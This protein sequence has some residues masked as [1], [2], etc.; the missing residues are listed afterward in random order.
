MM[1]EGVEITE[2]REPL[3]TH[4]ML[5]EGFLANLQRAGSTLPEAGTESLS[6]TAESVLQQDPNKNYSTEALLTNLFEVHDEMT[7]LFSTVH[8]S[9]VTAHNLTQTINKVASC[10]N[11]IGGK[12]ERFSALDHV[13][14]L[15][16][17]DLKKNATKVIDTTKQCYT[18]GQVSDD[19]IDNSGKTINLVFSGNEG[20]VHYKALGTITAHG[21]W[22]GN[23]AIDYV[24]T[25]SS[26]KL[27]VKAFESNRWDDKSA[28]YE[29]SWELEEYDKAQYE[30]EQRQEKTAEKTAPRK[31]GK[32]VS[33]RNK[34]QEV[35]DVNFPIQ[36]N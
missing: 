4:Q 27:S 12:M 24:Y 25:P 9:S 36:E 22:N 1:V 35:M 18:L 20:P 29:I 30:Q 26:G 5:M 28:H 10:I 13:S 14:G 16:A 3:D 8:H 32:P 15:Q 33:T 31:E 6:A 7:G 34:L 2:D 11:L 19:L 23:E 21:G 17:P